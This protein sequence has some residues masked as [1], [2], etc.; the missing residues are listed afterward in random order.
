MVAVDV[1]HINCWR[2][3]FIFSLWWSRGPFL[4]VIRYSLAYLTVENLQIVQA[5]AWPKFPAAM[6]RAE[7]PTMTTVGLQFTHH[8]PSLL[9]AIRNQNLDVSVPRSEFP[10]C[11]SVVDRRVLLINLTFGL[12]A[13]RRSDILKIQPLLL[14]FISNPWWWC[15]FRGN[16][17]I[18]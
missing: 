1:Q 13:R 11:S 18:P 15:L 7:E 10:T 3:F 2:A 12:N 9:E 8:K 4:A 17:T 16:I 6:V 5:F 14:Q